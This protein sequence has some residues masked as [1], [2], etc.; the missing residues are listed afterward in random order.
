LAKVKVDYVGR[1]PLAGSDDRKLLATLREGDR[2]ATMLAQNDAV[3]V[4]QTAR[5]AAP[6]DDDADEA[7][8]PVKVAS[9][10]D[11]APAFFDSR[12]M[13][14]TAAKSRVEAPADR[15]L[16]EGARE[17]VPPMGAKTVAKA[18]LRAPTTEFAARPQPAITAEAPAEPMVSPVSAY[19]PT[20]Y[21]QAPGFMSGRGLY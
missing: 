10:H 4:R 19:A 13:T 20:R 11:F 17:V 8:A 15:R 14:E 3:P 16:G 5:N 18:S 2:P 12:P 21:D 1:A 6:P 7:P 9:A